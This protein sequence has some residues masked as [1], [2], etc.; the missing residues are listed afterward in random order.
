[1][2]H[3]AHRVATNPYHRKPKSNYQTS[4]HHTPENVIHAR[5]AYKFSTHAQRL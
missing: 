3:A 2:D 5:H 4:Q 1:M